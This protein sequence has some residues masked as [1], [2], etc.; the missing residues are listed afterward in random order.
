MKSS[1]CL[2]KSSSSSQSK[3]DLFLEQ[4]AWDCLPLESTRMAYVA[5]TKDGH[6]IELDRRRGGQQASAINFP[7]LPL[8]SSRFQRDRASKV[9]AGSATEKEAGGVFLGLPHN[10]R[11]QQVKS[12]VCRIGWQTQDL[13]RSKGEVQG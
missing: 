10:F 6:G 12:K 3:L 2:G 1:F 7:F 4:E 13:P 11:G 5:R 9:C 8:I